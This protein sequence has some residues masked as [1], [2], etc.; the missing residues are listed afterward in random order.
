MSVFRKDIGKI[1]CN[2]LYVDDVYLP[3]LSILYHFAMN[4]NHLPA[5]D[6]EF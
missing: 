3:V 1:M 2:I 4:A 6:N 5:N